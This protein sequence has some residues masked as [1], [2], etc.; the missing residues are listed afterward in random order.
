MSRYT[1]LALSHE[2]LN[3]AQPDGLVLG[4]R[5]SLI[6][7]VE[8]SSFDPRQDTFRR[9]ITISTEQDTSHEYETRSLVQA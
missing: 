5:E 4:A 3:R 2:T 1:V 7:Y 6:S 9:V 8:L